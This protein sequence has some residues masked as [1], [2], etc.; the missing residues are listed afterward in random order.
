[1]CESDALQKYSLFGGLDKEQLAFMATLLKEKQYA[2]GEVILKEGELNSKVYFIK[3]GAVEIDKLRCGE[4][5]TAGCTS[6]HIADLEVGDTFGE[7]ELIDIQPCIATA[8]ASGEV[9]VL[10]L[11]NVDLYALRKKDMKAFTLVIMN[12]ARD[13]SRRLRVM[14]SRF[15][16]AVE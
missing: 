2:P 9:S 11:S 6:T 14:D 12:L 1:M 3:A 13:I 10:T 4:A 16:G 5:E 7:M 15:S 8:T